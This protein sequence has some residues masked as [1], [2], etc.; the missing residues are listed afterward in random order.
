MSVH[1][2]KKIV[3]IVK[4][5]ERIIEYKSSN[6][7]ANSVNLFLNHFTSYRFSN[8]GQIQNHFIYHNVNFVIVKKFE[9]PLHKKDGLVHIADYTVNH[10]AL[11]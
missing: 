10:K 7:S 5:T 11:F 4:L 6:D 9:C 3:V 1:F 2:V 8:F